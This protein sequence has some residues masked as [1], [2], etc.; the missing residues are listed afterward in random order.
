M[1][2][3]PVRAHKPKKHLKFSRI[4]KISFLVGTLSAV[5][6]MVLFYFIV[7][8]ARQPEN[9]PKTPASY[10]PNFEHIFLIMEENE[11]GRRIV[12]N[13]E[14]TYI[15]TLAD[16]YAY[17]TQYYATDHP[18]LP[19]YIHLT[20]GTNAGLMGNCGPTD[21]KCQL[22]VKNLPDLLEKN[23]LTWR[24]YIEGMPQPCD[25]NPEGEYYTEFNP[26]LYYKNIASNH[27]RCQKNDVPFSQFETDLKS[28]TLPNFVYIVP[29]N[30]NNMHNCSVG[31]GDQWL[32]KEVSTILDSPAFHNS[33]SLLVITWD[34][35]E[36]H[37]ST[38]NI[39]LIMVGSKVK[40]GYSSANRYDHM[41]LL[42]TIETAWGLPSMQADDK[43]ARPMS[44]F[45]LP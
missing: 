1:N 17:A 20:S 27:D 12:D 29:N 5:F 39:P 6:L 10:V 11:S 13:P 42:K 15:N 44:E 31:T 16:Q 9:V 23:R 2:H 3:L 24:A 41:S 8:S 33:V 38:N 18:S 37:E 36:E 34:E 14:A 35:S 22:D 25:P 32:A 19:N 7:A 45:F 4:Q 21:P 28:N 43:N 30:C 26:F 40:K